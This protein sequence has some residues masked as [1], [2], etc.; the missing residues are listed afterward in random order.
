MLPHEV[1][2]GT[3][4]LRGIRMKEDKEWLD[5]QERFAELYDYGN[6]N[7]PLQ[8]MVMRAGH[9]FCEKAFDQNDHFSKVLEVGGGSGVHRQYVRHSFNEYY[10][11]D[12]NEQVLAMACNAMGSSNP[13]IHFECQ[14]AESL[15]YPESTFDRLI[16]AHIL[17]HIHRPYLGL[18]DW[19]RVVKPGGVI[20]I[21]IPTDPGILWRFSRNFGP[22][23]RWLQMGIAYDY[24]V[25]REHVNPCNNLISFIRHYFTVRREYW[26]PCRIPS[27]DLNLFFVCHASN[28]KSQTS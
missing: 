25:S 18:K 5:Y 11:T 16:A 20:S 26:W 22:R 15:S 6:Y 27:M 21:L 23:R 4:T 7:R 2:R 24:C 8:N 28:V 19:C 13:R 12:C 14:R 1:Q 3:G 17:E 10:V 9:R